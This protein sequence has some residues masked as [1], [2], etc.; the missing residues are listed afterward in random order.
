MT[1]LGLK[2]GVCR[3]GL[4]AVVLAASSSEKT[5][6]TDHLPNEGTRHT[7]NQTPLNPSA[8]RF[9]RNMAEAQSFL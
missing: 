8:Q 4:C 3:R 2:K 9:N 6:L 7:T 1:P 5:N